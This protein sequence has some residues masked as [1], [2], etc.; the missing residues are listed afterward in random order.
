MYK[1]K[2]NTNPLAGLRWG[3]TVYKSLFPEYY[4][5]CTSLPTAL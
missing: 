2:A 1:G 3:L 5:I 4:I